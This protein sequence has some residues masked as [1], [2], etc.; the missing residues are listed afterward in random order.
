MSSTVLGVLVVIAFSVSCANGWEASH[1]VETSGP[2]RE[3]S[4][5]GVI[6]RVDSDHQ[7]AV[8]KHEKIE[9]WM[10]AMT[11]EFPVKDKREF[12]TLRPGLAI[13]AKVYLESEGP[14]Y[15]IADVKTE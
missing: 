14:G 3:Y 13:T 12:S 9:G 6:V 10:E 2:V 8:I 4:I 5:R 1:E 7:T 15:W 11:M